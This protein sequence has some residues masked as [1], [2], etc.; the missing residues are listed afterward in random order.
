MKIGMI[1]DAPFPPDYRV[2]KEAITLVQSGHK[3]ILFCL[4]YD[5]V[6]YVD[7]YQGFTV[8]H[9]PSNKLEYKLSALA[10]S[11]PFYHLFMKRKLRQFIAQFK[12]DIFHVHDMVIA[13]AVFTLANEVLVP[14]V[15]DLHENRPVSMSEY[16]HV[17]KFP[18][19]VLINIH[20][21]EKK[22]IELVQQANR[23]IV[24]TELAKRDLIEQSGKNPNEITVVPNTPSE[25]FALEPLCKDIMTRMG[26][27]FNIL[28]I[29]DTSVRRGTADAVNAMPQLLKS[30]PNAKLWIVGKSSADKE[31][32]ALAKSIGVERHV[33]FE[34]WQNQAL[35]S[36]YITGA[37][38]CISPLKRN[39]HHDTTYANK[40]FQYMALARPVVVSDC[41]A[42]AELVEQEKVGLV[43]K[44][45]DINGYCDSIIRLYRSESLR[46]QLGENA[47]LA[48]SQ[49][50][51]WEKT[52]EGLRAL[53]RSI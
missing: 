10:Y 49:R 22:Q 5:G 45:G 33:N 40:V 19:N 36:S 35:F 27:T 14:V 51:N 31:L 12:P 23:V 37:H 34:G 52:S 20:A 32:E 18:G 3:V 30:I 4:T 38:I 21:W 6:F 39:R 28:Y 48:I 7:D 46:H 43:H 42:Q 2:E 24:V 50:W 16:R 13:E 29:G 1:L 41:P 8:V 53:Y 9:Y 44:A 26:D 15:L 17:K 47:R 11:V 25:N